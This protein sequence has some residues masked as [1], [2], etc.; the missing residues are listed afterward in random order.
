MDHSYFRNQKKSLL[1]CKLCNLELQ[2]IDI[3]V[4]PKQDEMN[5]LTKTQKILQRISSF[6]RFPDSSLRT[7]DKI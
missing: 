7:S 5:S 6:C 2:R 1:G 4:M 3:I